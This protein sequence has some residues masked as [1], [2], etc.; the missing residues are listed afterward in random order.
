M[1]EETTCPSVG[2]WINCTSLNT[3]PFSNKKEGDIKPCKNMD[4]SWV[5]IAKWKKVIWKGFIIGD[6][7]YIEF[8]KR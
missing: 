4:E 1:V 2:E 3:L 5:C 8:L 7:I 6:T